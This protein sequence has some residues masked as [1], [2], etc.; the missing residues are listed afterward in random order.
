MGSKQANAP[1]EPSVVE[2]DTLLAGGRLDEAEQILIDLHQRNPDFADICNKMGQLYFQKGDYLRAK[3]FLNRAVRLNP[4]YTEASLNLAVTLNEIGQYN[5]AKK[6]IDQAKDRVKER[7]SLIDP[8]IAGKLANRHK[9]L[10]DIYRELGLLESSSEEYR[11][12]LSLAPGFA[13]IQVRLG[14]ALREMGFIDDALEVFSKAAATRPDY[15][16]SRIQLGITFFSRGFVDRA[17][18]EWRE[19]LKVDP[20]NQRAKMYMSFIR[21]QEG[22]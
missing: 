9:E 6:I 10:G 14:V 20:D 21:D 3:E 16:D 5:E 2:I 11:K 7:K 15:L 17:A 13:D 4:Y 18:T 8:F 12:A 1:T 19:V 22:R